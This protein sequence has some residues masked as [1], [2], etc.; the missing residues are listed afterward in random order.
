LNI[1]QHITTLKNE[2]ESELDGESDVEGEGD[3]DID[4]DGDF[5]GEINIS[6]TTCTQ[7]GS[8]PNVGNFIYY[9]NNPNMATTI[10]I[11]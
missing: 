5:D 2:L 9:K 6:T 3:L 7:V 8:C 1:E 10:V 11:D 4:V